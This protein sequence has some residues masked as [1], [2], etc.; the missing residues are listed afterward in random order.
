MPAQTY[1]AAPLVDARSFAE[2][3]NAPNWKDINPRVGIAYDLFGNGRTALKGNIGR[4]I[5][6]VTTGYSDIINPIVSA[7]NTATRTFRDANGDFY[8]DCDLRSIAANGECGPLSNVNFGRGILTTAFDREVL[9]GWGKRPFDWEI[10]A[11]IQH[12]LRS[13]VSLNATYIRHWWG[14]FLVTDNLAVNPSD[15]S[16]YCV[17]APVDS[18][19]PG[20]GG[21]QICGFYDV[22]PDK[23]G[24]VNNLITFAKNYGKQTDVY[25][26]L[27]VAA[28]VRLPRGVLLQ[29]GFNIGREAI[30]NCDVKARKSPGTAERPVRRRL[31]H[32]QNRRKP[33]RCQASTVSDLTMTSA[34]RHS[35]HLR[36][37]QTQ[38]T[39]S[40]VLSTP[41]PSSRCGRLG[42]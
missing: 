3:E 24:Q 31:F 10:Q 18:R 1:P 40:A 17:T 25:N 13:G 4:Y 15:Y 34:A 28:N 2:I 39:R 41:I 33:W 14:N 37:S 35:L 8:P 42:Q 32:V 21:N 9:N 19:L 38:R 12:E 16:S 11:G 22:N 23:F 29:G 36:D 26:G 7:V 5:E 20:G 27:D 6:A 30:N